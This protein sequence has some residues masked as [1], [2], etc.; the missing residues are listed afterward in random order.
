MTRARFVSNRD[1]SPRLFMTP[2]MERL[3]HVHPAVP[4][5]LYV[6][7]I[8]VFSWRASLDASAAALLGQLLVG[9]IVWSLTEYALHRWVFHYEPRSEWGRRIHFLSHG[10]H[11]DYPR[12]STRLVMPPAVSLPLAVLF[13]ASFQLLAGSRADGMFAGFVLGYLSYDMIHFATHHWPMQGRIGRFLKRYHLLHHYQD[14][15]SGF[16]VS[17]PL[18]DAVFGTLPSK[19]RETQP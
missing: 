18:W 10:V 16:G 3:S 19:Q 1:E 5:L 15:A 14:D 13:W 9:L 2:W 6:P 4:V 7:V 12:D 11:H 8:T 17:S